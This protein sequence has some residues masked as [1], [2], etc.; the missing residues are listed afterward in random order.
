MQLLVPSLLVLLL[1]LLLF[2]SCSTNAGLIKLVSQVLR[3]GH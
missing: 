1:L 3:E 2:L